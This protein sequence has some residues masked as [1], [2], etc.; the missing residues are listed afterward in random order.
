MW[1][2]CTS[3]VVVDI[4]LPLIQ[5]HPSILETFS[6]CGD[7]VPLAFALKPNYGPKV[8]KAVHYAIDRM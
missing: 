8:K 3:H 6:R 1:G 7:R 5:I 4:G 2:I